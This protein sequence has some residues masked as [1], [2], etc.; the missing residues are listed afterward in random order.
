MLH[1][2]WRD[3]PIDQTEPNLTACLG[4]VRAKAHIRGPGS[5]PPPTQVATHGKHVDPFSRF[6]RQALRAA[7]GLFFSHPVPARGIGILR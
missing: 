2:A 7:A 1:R 6:L 5:R 3:Q 4:E